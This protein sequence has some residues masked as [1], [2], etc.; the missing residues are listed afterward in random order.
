[1]SRLETRLEELGLV[2]P[3]PMNPPGNFELVT[4]HA[5]LANVAGHAA[6]DGSTLLV[7]GVVGR[8]LTIEQAMRP[9]D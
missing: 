8:D 6:I 4:E 3:T 7:E 1:M 5:G 2:L 9:R